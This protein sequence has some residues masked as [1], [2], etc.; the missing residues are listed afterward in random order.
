MLAE[1]L[2]QRLSAMSV[3]M[4]GVGEKCNGGTAKSCDAVGIH[5]CTT[6]QYVCAPGPYEGPCGC[7]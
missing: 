7:C 3:N 5:A 6:S 2:W 4:F 1:L